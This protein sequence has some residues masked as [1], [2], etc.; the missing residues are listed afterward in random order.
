[1]NSVASGSFL[2]VDV[3]LHSYMQQLAGWDGMDEESDFVSGTALLPS[4][5]CTVFE[6]HWHGKLKH[7]GELTNVGNFLPKLNWFCLFSAFPCWPFHGSPTSSH[8]FIET[9]TMFSSTPQF[10]FWGGGGWVGGNSGAQAVPPT[11]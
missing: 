2:V 7:L 6:T 3:H 9:Y 8:R 4:V 11:H 10:F 1:M 5:P